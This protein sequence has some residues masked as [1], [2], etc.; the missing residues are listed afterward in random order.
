[1]G[2]FTQLPEYLSIIS[3]AI[4]LMSALCILLSL[5]LFI[6]YVQRRPDGVYK[7]HEKNGIGLIGA[8]VGGYGGVGVPPLLLFN[9]C[10]PNGGA[11][12]GGTASSNSLTRPLRFPQ[13]SKGLNSPS[14]VGK[15]SAEN[16]GQEKQPMI[17]NNME[18]A[19][20]KSLPTKKTTTTMATNSNKEY[21]C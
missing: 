13:N 17:M 8:G 7:T 16:G 21:F 3:A 14:R 6:L 20:S 15:V 11:E 1:M 10:G 18:T 12:K 4:G 19:T 9:N 2:L 5:C